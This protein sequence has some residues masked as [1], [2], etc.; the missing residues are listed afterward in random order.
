MGALPSV[1]AM[2]IAKQEEDLQ[3]FLVGLLLRRRMLLN[4]VW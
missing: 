2:Q 3:L 1:V 4:E